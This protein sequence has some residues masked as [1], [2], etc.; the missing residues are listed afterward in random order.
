[1]ELKSKLTILIDEEY[2]TIEVKDEKSSQRVLSIKVS[3]LEFQK[4]LARIACCDCDVYYNTK[5]FDK[6]GKTLEVKSFS[7]PLP[8]CNFQNRRDIAKEEV[9]KICPTGYIPD[10]SFSSQD[11]FTEKDGK[12]YAKTTIRTWK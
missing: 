11:S 2:T 10:V 1:M 4:A 8:E 7:F 12:K 3:P 5:S 9:L 6:I